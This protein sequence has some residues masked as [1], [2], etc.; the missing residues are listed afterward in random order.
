[1]KLQ[2]WFDSNNLN[3]DA[4]RRGLAVVLMDSGYPNR[5]EL[6]NLTDYRVSSVRGGA[7]WLMP[8]L[9]STERTV[10][11][12]V[13]NFAL[14]LTQLQCEREKEISLERGDLFRAR[15]FEEWILTNFGETP[16]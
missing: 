3:L 2:D 4:C 9:T 1:M 15:C 13:K 14:P 12:A 6:W 10:W 7:I 5:S 11:Q 8:N 16:A